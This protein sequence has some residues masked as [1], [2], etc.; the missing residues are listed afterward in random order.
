MDTIQ[1]GQALCPLDI[2]L[3][4]DLCYKHDVYHKQI[5]EGMDC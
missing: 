2:P 4:P 1:S 3:P 5:K